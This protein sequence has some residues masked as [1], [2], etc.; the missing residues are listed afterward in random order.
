MVDAALLLQDLKRLL[1]NLEADLRDVHA[2]S[3]A[4]RALQAEWQAARDAG[5]TGETLA[6]FRN[7][8]LTQAVAHWILGC[9]FL[10][11]LEDNAL[12]ER[13]WLAGP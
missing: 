5:R 12:V 7:D 13:P 8:A 11:F 3:D 9:V 4:N 10:R 1:R 6:D 2:D